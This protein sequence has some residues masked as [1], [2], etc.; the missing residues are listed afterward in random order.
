MAEL[1]ALAKDLT[2]VPLRLSDKRLATW[3]ACTTTPPGGQQLHGGSAQ[4]LGRGSVRAVTS[5]QTAQPENTAKDAQVTAR[6]MQTS[7]LL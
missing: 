6:A 3:P 4:A 2:K 1:K 7:L 5:L